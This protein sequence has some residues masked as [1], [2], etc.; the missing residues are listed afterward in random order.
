MKK[1]ILIILLF[2]VD[3]NCFAYN[4]VYV[5]RKSAS[6]LFQYLIRNPFSTRDLIK[7]TPGKIKEITGKRM[8][9]KEKIILKLLQ[10]KLKKNL[11]E[12]KIKNENNPGT[13]SILLG[14]LA[15]AGLFATSIPVLGFISLFS[16]I[17]AVI[18]GIKGLR[19]NKKDPSSL[20]GLILGGAYLLL[21]IIFI[22]FVINFGYK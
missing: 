22:V 10:I 20:I 9:L 4:P 1:L 11:S 18:W 2:S 7:L 14:I 21:A 17:G 12:E 3:A 5:S 6:N 8:L 16:A 19:R 13:L 15:I